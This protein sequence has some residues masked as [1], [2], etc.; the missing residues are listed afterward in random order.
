M[1]LAHTIFGLFGQHPNS[2]SERRPDCM[3]TDNTVAA[4]AEFRSFLM[5]RCSE[6]CAACVRAALVA[7]I[8]AHTPGAPA[9]AMGAG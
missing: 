6:P 3:S 2:L 8:L 7:G 1:F 9:G 5:L 4:S